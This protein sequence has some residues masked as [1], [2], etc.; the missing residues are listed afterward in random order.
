ML[1]NCNKTILLIK[2]TSR[3]KYGDNLYIW[4]K[5]DIKTPVMCYLLSLQ[6]NM[7]EK[8]FFKLSNCK[9]NWYTNRTFF[10]KNFGKRNNFKNLWAGEWF[11]V[12]IFLECLLFGEVCFFS[13]PTRF[14]SWTSTRIQCY[15]FWIDKRT[16]KN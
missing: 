9:L 16:R 7:R 10:K 15:W 13:L 1:W 8:E 14:F 5:I 12:I 2:F 11:Q 6:G 4:K 3:Y